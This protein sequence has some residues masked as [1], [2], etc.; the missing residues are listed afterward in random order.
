MEMWRDIRRRVI[1]EGESKRLI[2]VSKYSTL[3]SGQ[4]FMVAYLQ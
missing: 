4:C 2:A 1:V 3:H